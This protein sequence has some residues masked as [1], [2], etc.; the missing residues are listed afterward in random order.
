MLY[1]KKT[2]TLIRHTLSAPLIFSVFIPLVIF[3]V[4][5][6]LYHRICFPLYRIPTIKRGNYIKIDRQK[7]AYLTPLQK[8]Y[9][10]YCGYANG[11][12]H[13]W[14]KIA[15]ETEHYWCGIQHKK[16]K[17]YVQQ[18]HQKDFAK[19]GDEKKFRKKYYD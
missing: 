9:C 8:V 7:L 3:D 11:A 2:G 12:V 16:S 19:Y 15:A 14:S 5:V 4:W 18:K 1:I 17:G 13:Y 6:E 10:V